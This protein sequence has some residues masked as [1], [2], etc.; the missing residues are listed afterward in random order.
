MP[1]PA[2]NPEYTVRNY[3]T[4]A[5]IRRENWESIAGDDVLASYGWLKTVEETISPAIKPRYLVAENAGRLL[6]A[7]VCYVFSENSP[8]RTA[9]NIFLGRASLLANR[10]GLSFLPCMICGPIYC[11]GSHLLIDPAAGAGERYRLTELLV[12]ALEAL[13]RR[14]R[15]ALYFNGVDDDE[16]ADLV[17][18]LKRRRYFV[19]NGR[20]V[21]ALDVPWSSFADYMAFIRKTRGKKAYND[22]KLQLNRNKK[23][24]V[25]ID[26]V[27]NPSEIDDRIAHLLEMQ[28]KKYGQA[29]S[30]FRK[31]LVCAMKRN[32]GKRAR[33]YV[34]RKS[35]LVTGVCI[36]LKKQR[37]GYVLITGIDHAAGNDFTYFNLVYYRPIKDAIAEKTNRLYFGTEVYRLKFRRGCRCQPVYLYYKPRNRFNEILLAPWSLFIAWWTR[38]K[39]NKV[40]AMEQ[41][42]H[43]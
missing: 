35:G 23:Q 25:K 10:V 26:S 17:N 32:L 34:A 2:P 40:V 38:R 22:I 9:D 29:S 21:C 20:P 14:H 30:V 19:V 39:L 6:G 5:S 41:N 42:F 7:S 43:P 28:G 31:S 3:A 18:S 16:E 33:I 37:T 13:A 8:S 15:L 27:E 1:S 4:I 36:V 11:V 24:G 12:D